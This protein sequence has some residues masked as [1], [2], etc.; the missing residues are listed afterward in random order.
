VQ[1]NTS[2]RLRDLAGQGVIG[3][4]ERPP[5]I[6]R[7]CE[8]NQRSD[9]GRGPQHPP[10]RHQLVTCHGVALRAISSSPAVLLYMPVASVPDGYL[11]ITAVRKERP[12]LHHLGSIPAKS[13]LGHTFQALA[14]GDTSAKQGMSSVTTR[15]PLGTN[16]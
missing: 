2:A 8:N 16:H 5:L 1:L 13:V 6:I 15:L 12:A 3:A 14:S 9:G 10:R 11:R 4:R 7:R